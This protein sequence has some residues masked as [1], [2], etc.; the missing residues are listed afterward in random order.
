M[1]RRGDISCRYSLN[2]W[3]GLNV[4]VDKG[5]ENCELYIVNVDKSTSG[6]HKVKLTSMLVSLELNSF[7]ESWKFEF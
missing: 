1:C 7:I 2:Y 3:K 4:T 6:E 5:S